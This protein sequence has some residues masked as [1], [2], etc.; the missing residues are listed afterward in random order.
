M[1]KKMADWKIFAGL[2]YLGLVKAHTVEDAFSKGAKKWPKV[3]RA[4]LVAELVR[5]EQELAA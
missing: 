4:E 2:K 1:A 5:E 3:L